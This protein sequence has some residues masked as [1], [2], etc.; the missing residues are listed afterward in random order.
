L[1]NHHLAL[2]GTGHSSSEAGIRSN[3]NCM[4][5]LL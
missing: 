5:M 3:C 2:A 1:N 4:K